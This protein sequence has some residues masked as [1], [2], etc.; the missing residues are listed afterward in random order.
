MN[1]AVPYHTGKLKII[2]SLWTRYVD[3]G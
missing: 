2:N 3:L 1:L